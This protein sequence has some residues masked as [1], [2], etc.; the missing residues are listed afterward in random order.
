[1]AAQP[2]ARAQTVAVEAEQLRTKHGVESLA[3]LIATAESRSV[4]DLNALSNL[5]LGQLKVHNDRAA[6]KCSS[7]KALDAA[8]GADLMGNTVRARMLTRYWT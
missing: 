1:M 2:D 3:P 7:L 5:K 4:I 8:L 6:D